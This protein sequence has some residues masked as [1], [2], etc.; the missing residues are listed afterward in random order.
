MGNRRLRAEAL[1]HP[2]TAAEGTTIVARTLKWTADCRIALLLDHMLRDQGCSMQ[3]R[4]P[5]EEAGTRWSCETALDMTACVQGM[6][7]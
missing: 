3:G 2:G 4:M 6:A 5:C 7:N 1:Q